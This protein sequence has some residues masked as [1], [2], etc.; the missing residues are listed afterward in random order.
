M[1]H[2]FNLCMLLLCLLSGKAGYAQ[3]AAWLPKQPIAGEKVVLSFNP[4]GGDLEFSDKI[5][6]ELALYENFKWKSDQLPLKKVGDLWTAGYTIPENVVFVA[7]KFF[8]GTREKIE[9]LDNNNGKGFFTTVLAKNKKLAPGGYLAEALLTSPGQHTYTLKGFSTPSNNAGKIDSLLKKETSIR[10]SVT[11]AYLVD[12]LNLKKN[13]M[14]ATAFSTF[15]D[16]VLQKQLSV[17]TTDEATLTAIQRYYAIDLKNPAGAD[18]AE[19]VIMQKF[20]TGNTARFLTYQRVNSTTNPVQYRLAAEQFLKAFPDLQAGDKNRSQ[21][22]LYYTTYRTLEASYFESQQYDKFLAMFKDFDFKTANEVYRW[23]ITKAEMSNALDKKTY[24]MLSQQII[25]MLI[26]KRTDGSYYADFGGDKQKEQ[27]NADQQLDDRL[28]SHIKLAYALKNYEEGLNSYKFLQVE[29]QY[30]YADLNELR[31]DMYKQTGK[32]NLVQALLEKSVKSNAVT[33]AMF[34]ELKQIY[35]TQH[36]G[37]AGGYEEYL[38]K[39]VPDDIKA[40]MQTHVMANMVH[41]PLTPFTL[42]NANGNSVSSSEWKDKI[43]VIDF[44]ATWCRPCIEAFPGMQLL[45]D[46]YAK[47]PKIAVYMIGTMQFGD[48]KTKSVNY[49]KSKGFRFNLLHDGIGANGEQNEVFRSLVP[50]FKSSGIPRK[51]IVKNGEVRYSSEGYSGSPSQLKDELSMA[52]E[53]LRKEK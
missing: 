10:G 4:K 3:R 34:D 26:A 14:D 19:N 25:P 7:V 37:N 24:F 2:I 41:Y 15:A 49:V 8:Q 50:L 22:F 30:A 52:I 45:I 16:Q 5:T 18:K 20:P 44:W 39:L 9:A 36:K 17:K 27:A 33:P 32:A 35:T 38:S 1:K 11:S 53:I 29:K 48:Y 6:A 46:Q 42:E 21:D 31:M 28:T 23:N 40:E 12:Y 47:D 43:V 13:T 51:V